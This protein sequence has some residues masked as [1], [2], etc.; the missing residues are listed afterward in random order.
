MATEEVHQDRHSQ[1]LDRIEQ[2]VA[3]ILNR[4]TRMEERQNHHAVDLSA[5]AARLDA[6]ATR[7]AELE[8]RMAVAGERSDLTAKRFD[9][10]WAIAGAVLLVIVTAV[11]SALGQALVSMITAPAQQVSH[12]DGASPEQVE[13]LER[14]EE[15]LHSPSRDPKPSATTW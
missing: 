12:L 1:Q 5:H 4:V 15:R 8:L 3:Q 6:L 14:L 2:S 13:S 11:G 10:R 7:I 9:G